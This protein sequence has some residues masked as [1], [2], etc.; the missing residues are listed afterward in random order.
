MKAHKITHSNAAAVQRIMESN[1]DYSRRVEGS[2]PVSDAAEGVLSALP[3]GVDPSQKMDLGLWDGDELVA[4]A[5]VIVG[6]PAPTVAHIGLLMTD[7]VRRGQGLG[8]AMHDAVIDAVG[9]NPSIQTLSLSVVDT[10]AEVAGPFW[11]RLGYEPTG[12]AAPYA[13]GTVESVAR[14]WTRPIAIEEAVALR[15]LRLA[16]A[17]QV[18]E[19]FASNPDMA[20]Q[21]KVESLEDAERYVSALI[22]PDSPH[23]AWALTSDDVLVGLVCV[24]VDEEHRSGWFWYWMTFG[25]RGRGWTGRAAAT[26]ADWALTERGLERLELG[27][28][29]NNPASGAVA[30]R[31]GFVREGCE[32][33]KFLVGGERIDVL[34]YGRLRSDPAPAFDPL[35]MVEERPAPDH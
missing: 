23:E 26:V 12:D 3:P 6:W 2:G 7:G 8:R 18:Q 5:D 19:A 16:D 30:A 35:P 28:R 32:R 20:R 34:T 14:I 4:F 22:D 21:G 13:S 1:H 11:T 29:A 31:A 9:T 10:N 27:H 17:A 24:S 33:S 25:A 15:R